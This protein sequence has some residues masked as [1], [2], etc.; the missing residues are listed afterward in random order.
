MPVNKTPDILSHQKDERRRSPSAERNRAH[1]YDVLKGLVPA[2][3]LLLEVASGTG[4][5]AAWIGPKLAPLIWQTSE[6]ASEMFSS[7]NSHITHAASDNLYSP[8][9]IDVTQNGWGL[10]VDKQQELNNNINVIT[11]VNT[12]SYT[13]LTLPT[14]R[15]V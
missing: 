12:V 5:H 2:Q 10:D 6:Y 9:L 3:G 8:L 13:H 15:I 11:C 1:I 7:I 4:D 14:K